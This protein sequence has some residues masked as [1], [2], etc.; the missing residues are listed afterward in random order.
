MP[1]RLHLRRRRTPEADLLQQCRQVLQA[2]GVFHWRT[3]CGAAL[4]ET[5]GRRRYIRFTSMSGVADLI[6]ILP[7]GR[8][9]AVET[10]SRRGRLRPA[11]AVFLDEVRRAGGVGVVVTD[12]SELLMALAAEGIG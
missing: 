1:G 12:I 8:M 7:G 6:G 3:N 2:L 4:A 9:L 10:K 11:Q 5:N